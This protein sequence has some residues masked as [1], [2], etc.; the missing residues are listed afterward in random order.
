VKLSELISN[1]LSGMVKV[2]VWIYVYTLDDKYIVLKALRHGS[3]NPQTT[4]CLPLAFVHVHQM[5]PP[6]TVVKTFSCSLLHINFVD[7]KE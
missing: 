2:H 3:H 5:A 1:V 4:P 6:R 7:P